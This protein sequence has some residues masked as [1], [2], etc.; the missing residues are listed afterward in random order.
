MGQQLDILCCLILTSV[1]TKEHDPVTSYIQKVTFIK[2]VAI[3]VCSGFSLYGVSMEMV[4]GHV[5]QG[6]CDADST[7]KHAG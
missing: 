5:H 7:H 3:E 1:S 4:D 6:A 2:P